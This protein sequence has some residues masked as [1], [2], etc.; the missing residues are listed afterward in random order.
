MSLGLDA[1]IWGAFASA[2]MLALTAGVLTRLGMRMGLTWAWSEAWAVALGVSGALAAV[3]TRIVLEQG[4]V[5]EVY[6]LNLFI[7]AVLL[8]IA[9][10]SHKNPQS[11]LLFALV[12]G[13]GLANHTSFILPLIPLAVVM[14][15]RLPS[16][17]ILPVAGL[18]FLLG[19]SVWLYL[20]LRAHATPV[21]AWGWPDNWARF[22]EHVFRSTYG[23]MQPTRL[24][25]LPRHLWQMIVAMP[26]ML[27]WFLLPFTL[28]GFACLWIKRRRVAWILLWILIFTGPVAAV[29][30][31]LL[32]QPHQIGEFLIWLAPFYFVLGLLAG[33]GTIIGMKWLFQHHL[34]PLVKVATIIAGWVL[35]SSPVIINLPAVSKAGYFYAEDYGHNLLSTLAYRSAY[36]A[37]L[38]NSLGTFETAYLVKVRQLRPDVRFVDL[39]ATV[40]T[41]RTDYEQF[42]IL[43]LEEKERWRQETEVRA[44]RS[45]LDCYY[46]YLSP[47]P[48][49]MGFALVDDGMLFRAVPAHKPAADNIIPYYCY[50]LRGLDELPPDDEWAVIAAVRYRTNLGVILWRQG[51]QA[52]GQTELDEAQR[53]AQEETWALASIGEA[54]IY[55]GGWEKAAELYAESIDVLPP[56]MRNSLEFAWDIGG[57]YLNLAIVRAK[58]GDRE[59]A[60]EALGKV[61]ELCPQLL[62]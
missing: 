27:G 13:L 57:L 20:P 14:F 22:W 28:L 61:R 60:D 41:G 21:I 53:T 37:E 3:A 42:R 16:A 49:S 17:R 10:E 44:L 39:T 51:R 26:D 4:T 40:F 38:R 9:L 34:S 52:E 24:D 59:G 8:S 30:L 55:L 45:G 15:H 33:W 48:Q 31:T 2:L 35:I 47:L 32:L 43:T 12:T 46:S 11:L 7:F 23:G 18:M 25:F 36:I 19:L 5:A 62:R 54:W 50:S 1:A 56:E 58:T 29:L 6:A